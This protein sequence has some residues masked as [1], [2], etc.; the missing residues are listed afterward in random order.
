MHT[1]GGRDEEEVCV[2]I[3][4]SPILF[5]DSSYVH[6][7]KQ[8]GNAV[9]FTRNRNRGDVDDR[10]LFVD[11]IWPGSKYLARFLDE[12][13]D[14]IDWSHANVVELGAGCALPSIIAA[15][16]GASMVVATD[17]PAPGVIETITEVFNRNGIGSQAVGQALRWGNLQDEQV[18]LSMLPKTSRGFNLVLVAEPLW[19]DTVESHT[20]LASSLS[21]LLAPNEP[22]AVAY[23]CFCHRPNDRH[24]PEDDLDFF[25]IALERFKLYSE[26]VRTISGEYRD[27]LD[28]DENTID[29]HLYRL[30]RSESVSSDR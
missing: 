20:D 25:T 16:R 2:E 8:G 19:K 24:K 27:V 29:V 18:L 17:Y 6:K 12:D 9:A 26:K 7:L 13:C 10:P 3:T 14:V 23:V 30:Y 28:D 21:R 15:R 5:D 11:D 22:A 1:S 4:E